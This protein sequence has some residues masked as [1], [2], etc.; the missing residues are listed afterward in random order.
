MT[1]ESKPPKIFYWWPW[2]QN[3][4]KYPTDDLGFRTTIVI[5]PIPLGS[6]LPNILKN[7]SA[8]AG[9]TMF[10]RFNVR[11]GQLR[12]VN[13]LWY[14]NTRRRSLTNDLKN[15]TT[16]NNLQRDN[17]VYQYS[18]QPALKASPPLPPQK[19]LLTK[20][21]QNPLKKNIPKIFFPLPNTFFI[22]YKPHSEKN[23]LEKQFLRYF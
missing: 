13:G 3:S 18:L 12:K 7:N 4:H 20:W 15:R 21:P 9:V 8:T 11:I 6:K 5:L 17:L 22:N 23:P 14:K 10:S 16:K 2:D 19:N 1:L